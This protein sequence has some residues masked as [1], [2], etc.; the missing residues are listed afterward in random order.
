MLEN[1][2]Q[3][4]L[5]CI[6][7]LAIGCTVENNE[8]PFGDVGTGGTDSVTATESM[9]GSASVDDGETLPTSDASMTSITATA[10]DT[11]VIGECG[12]M[13]ACVT[14]PPEGWYGPV[15]IALGESGS[16]G[17]ECVDGY[18]DNGPTLLRGYTDPG[19]AECSCEC[20]LNGASSCFSYVYDMNGCSTYETFLQITQDCHAFAI[21]GGAYYTSFA[22]GMGFCQGM[23]TEDLPAPIW[24][25]QITTCKM[26]DVGVSCGEGGVC[27]PAAPEGFESALCIYMEGEN[28]CP[29]G[30]FTEQFVTYS[31]VDDTRNC[32]NCACGMAAATC[33]GALQ[34]Y[35]SDDCTGAPLG[36]CANNSCNAALNGG[37][38]VAVDYGDGICPVMTPPMAEGTITTTGA[39]TYCCQPA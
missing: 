9:T 8:D 2:I 10:E 3:P 26:E 24:E 17:P 18:P 7:V 12:P 33:M 16:M 25:A 4:W 23:V 29:A 38:S 11:G 22:Q 13:A 32:T 21:N 30:D 20:M 14:Q 15:A 19:P 37:G 39:F 27:A 28:E 6:A 35:A 34:V 1:R 5:S 31:G 36:E